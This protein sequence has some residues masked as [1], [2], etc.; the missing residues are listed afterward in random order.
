MKVENPQ[1]YRF[2]MQDEVY[3]LEQ[4]KGLT[5]NSSA[6]P[7]PAGANPAPTQTEA[8]PVAAN[9]PKPEPE[10]VTQPPAVQPMVKTQQPAFNY[11]GSNN[12]RFLILTHYPHDEFIAPAHLTALESI[13]KR[14]D[15]AVDDVV[16]LNTFTYPD[17]GIK[18]IHAHFKPEKILILGANAIPAGLKMPG[19]NQP[20]RTSAIAILYSFSFDEMMASNEN[21]KIFWEQMKTL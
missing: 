14:K 10:A 13:L 2:I 7:A 9:A 17:A 20:L 4:D 19:L 6:A 18:Q 11:M 1:A 3:L 8:L 12:K 15:L 5:D 21:K 16:I